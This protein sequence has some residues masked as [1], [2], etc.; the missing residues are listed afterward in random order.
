MVVRLL[1]ASMLSSPFVTTT[2]VQE[3]QPACASG[4][5]NIQCTVEAGVLRMYIF[6]SFVRVSTMPCSA[7]I[8]RKPR[9]A[10]TS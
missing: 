6:R 2:T 3:R 9:R 8:V 5:W 4:T 7:S 10:G 1:S